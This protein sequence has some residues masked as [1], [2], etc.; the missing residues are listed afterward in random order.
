[1]K[2]ESIVL[3]GMA[4]TGK[5]TIGLGLAKALAFNFTD[6]DEYIRNMDG[7]TIQSIIDNN[8]EDV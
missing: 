2:K 1:M 8:G 4:G 5:S 6:L 3:I 7:Q